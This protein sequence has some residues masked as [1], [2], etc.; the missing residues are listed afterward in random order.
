MRRIVITFV[1]LTAV[2]GVL[3]VLHLWLGI[4]AENTYKRAGQRLSNT[5]LISSI[6]INFDRG[7]LHSTV[8]TQIK[9]RGTGINVTIVDN[10]SH[11]PISTDRLLQGQFDLA[12]VLARVHS[13]ITAKNRDGVD[14]IPTF[15]ARTVI[16]IDRN[17]KTRVFAGAFK[18][19]SRSKDTLE[20][21]GFAGTI[22]FRP[23]LKR[24]IGSFAMP[25]LRLTGMATGVEME[26]L[27]TSFDFHDGIS[28]FSIG[29]LTVTSRKLIYRATPQDP[30]PL[31]ASGLAIHTS[32]RDHSDGVNATLKLSIEGFVAGPAKLGPGLIKIQL[33]GLD[34]TTLA[35]LRHQLTDRKRAIGQN[36]KTTFSGLDIIRDLSRKSPRIS[37]THFSVG[38]GNEEVHGKGT[39]MMEGDKIKP[40]AGLMQLLGAINASAKLSLPHSIISTLVT[41][42]VRFELATL[43]ALGKIPPLSIEQANK[44]IDASVEARMP[45]W[46]ESH[47]L[48]RRGNGYFMDL[49]YKE[50]R[51]V[52]NGELI[53][54]SI[55]APVPPQG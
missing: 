25:S 4:E 6:D 26:G 43:Q 47:W 10:I 30:S 19:Y 28:G 22:R 20:S 51:L 9:I 48:E 49:V 8:N 7:W 40:D 36:T 31:T 41:T 55:A 21:T 34:P 16:S 53:D 18:S 11:G 39:L 52:I 50:G 54:S 12:P 3:L 1:V 17:A 37:I 27:E 44:I 46:P 15:S 29:D 35:K 45:D 13:E 33:N 38:S 24:I 14:I 23:G 2:I 42:Q 32:A 5:A